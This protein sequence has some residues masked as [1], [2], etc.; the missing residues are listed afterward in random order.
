MR[1]ES[2]DGAEIRGARAPLI[3]M[4]FSTR[5]VDFAVAC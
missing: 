3:N 4:A 5:T 1:Q 2:A